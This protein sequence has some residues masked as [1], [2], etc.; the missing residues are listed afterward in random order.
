MPGNL[1]ET[2][3]RAGCQF[4]FDDA[5]RTQIDGDNTIEALCR[6]GH[7]DS[8]AA[9]ERRLHFGPASWRFSI[10]VRM[11]SKLP[12]ADQ[13]CCAHGRAATPTEACFKKVRRFMRL[14]VQIFVGWLQ[15]RLSSIGSARPNPGERRSADTTAVRGEP[16]AADL[17]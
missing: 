8:N 16:F 6:G 7:E 3:V 15:I 1:V 12:C 13:A 4:Q 11:G 2:S 14:T 17:H 9:G 10:S 5:F